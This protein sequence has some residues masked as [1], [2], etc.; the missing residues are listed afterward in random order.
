MTVYDYCHLGHA[1]VMIVFDLVQR[2]LKAHGLRVT[3][4]R[5][6]T[7]I[8]DKI[9]QRAQD[10]GESISSL[11]ERMIGAM[12]AD[13]DMLNVE[14]PTFEPRATKHIQE[15]IELIQKL[16]DRGLAYITHHKD[17]NYATRR[18]PDYGKLSKKDLDGLHAGKRIA[19]SDNKEDVLDFVLWKSAKPEEPKEAQWSSPYGKGR[20]GWHIECSAMAQKFLG[21]HFDIHGGGSDLQFPHHEN[22]IAQSEGANQQTFA[23]TWMHVGFLNVNHTKMSKSLGN[24]QTIRETLKQYDPQTIR[25]FILRTHYRSPLNYSTKQLDD[26]ESG[27]KRLHNTLHHIRP[28][29]KQPVDWN[30]PYAKA[31]KEAMDKD[32]AT[33]QAIA[34]L[35]DLANVIRASN[36]TLEKQ[37]HGHTLKN[38]GDILGLSLDKSIKQRHHKNPTT[39]TS[40]QK[41]NIEVIEDKMNQRQVAKTNRNFTLA[42]A[43]RQ[44]LSDMGVTLQDTPEGTTWQFRK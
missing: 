9:I 13:T 17:V 10:N 37:T 16:Q 42:D 24:F 12:H 6:I 25:F 28:I 27:L 5:N 41:L 21:S 36:N 22:E 11:T 40:S 34:V 32:F 35:F 23:N 8:D 43:L 38:L 29:A 20:P 44:E 39:Q 2:W 15:M 19:I 4:V 30:T 7:D 1:R 33:P 31:F 3:Y 26:A 18:F 14:R